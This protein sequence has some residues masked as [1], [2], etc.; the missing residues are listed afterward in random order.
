MR[1]EATHPMRADKP[2]LGWLLL[3]TCCVGAVAG[4][5]VVVCVLAADPGLLGAYFEL[6]AAAYLVLF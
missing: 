6:R 4:V 1:A 3:L 2:H 5:V